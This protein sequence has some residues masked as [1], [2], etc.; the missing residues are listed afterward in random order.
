MKTKNETVIRTKGTHNHRCDSGKCE[1]KEVVNQIKTKAQ[2]STPTLAIANEMSEI[3]DDY[4]VQLALP[5]NDNLLRVVSR[6]QQYKMCLQIPA[7]TDRHFEVPDEFAPFLLQDSGI[8]DKKRI[9]IFGKATMKNT[10]TSSNTWLVDG[11]FKLSPEI[12]YPI[13]AIHA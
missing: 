8:D 9:L 1:S 12:F 3:S 11:T 5:R 13:Y 2:Y 7:P 4:A 6:K 10:M